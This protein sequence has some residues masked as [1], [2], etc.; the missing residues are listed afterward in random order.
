VAVMKREV[1]MNAMS[2]METNLEAGRPSEFTVPLKRQQQIGVT[3]GKVEQRHFHHAIRAAG[4]VA[5]DKQRQ[6]EYVTR[7]DGYIQK[8][9]VF[10]PGESVEQ[11]APLLTI[12]SPELYTAQK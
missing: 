9:N 4:T 6:W 7:V 3:F 10:S 2:G 8:L 12:F 5:Y 1:Q 11:G